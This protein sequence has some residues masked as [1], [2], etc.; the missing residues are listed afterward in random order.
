[1]RIAGLTFV[2]PQDINAFA[3]GL[4]PL[5]KYD[6]ADIEEMRRLIMEKDTKA[7]KV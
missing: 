3:D 5:V 4:E 6:G 1:L 7:P 2:S